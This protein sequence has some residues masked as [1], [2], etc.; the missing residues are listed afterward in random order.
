MSLLPEIKL[1]GEQAVLLEWNKEISL[2]IQNQVML[3][4]HYID[5]VFKQHIIETVPAFYSL[6]IYLKKETEIQS[7]IAGLKGITVISDI[8]RKPHKILHIPVCYDKEFGLDLTEMTQHLKLTTEE[9]VKRHCSKTYQVYFLGFLPGFPYLGGLDPRISV[10]RK[11]SPRTFVKAGSVGIAGQ[12]T[13]V[14]TQDSPGGWNIIGRS[15]LRF[16]DVTKMEPCLI[17]P[18]DEVRFYSISR[19]QFDTISYEVAAQTFNLRT[20][21]NDV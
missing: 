12:Q 21:V 10:E 11:T 7:F 4:K 16:F 20:E 2:S 3:Y 5:T 8:N 13:G 9:I 1:F 17:L 19:K 15:P 14:Y 18:G 6:A